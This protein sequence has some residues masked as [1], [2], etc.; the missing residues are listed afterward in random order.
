M[1]NAPAF[2][3]ASEALDMVHAGLAFLAAADA[4]AMGAAERA[5]CLRG[6]EQADAVATAART[7]VLGAFAGGAGLRG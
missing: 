2:A 4:T 5:S 3:S 6:L 7:S 1:G